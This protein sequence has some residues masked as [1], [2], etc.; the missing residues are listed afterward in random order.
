MLFNPIIGYVDVSMWQCI[1]EASLILQAPIPQIGQTH[2]KNSLV[3]ASKLFECV[4]PF[5]GLVL[6]GLK[7]D[8]VLLTPLL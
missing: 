3:T 6:K 1:A 4:W 2:S 7:F 5:L 8:K